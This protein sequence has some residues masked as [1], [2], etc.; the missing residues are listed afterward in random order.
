MRNLILAFLCVLV[1]VACDDSTPTS[2]T[3][4]T[5]LATDAQSDAAD[6]AEVDPHSCDGYGAYDEWLNV[7]CY[8][9]SC[10]DC[11]RGALTCSFKWYDDVGGCA[12]A[13]GEPD[14][15][16]YRYEYSVAELVWPSDLE[17]RPSS[18]VISCAGYEWMNRAFWCTPG[19]G[20]SEWRTCSTEEVVGM[21]TLYCEKTVNH[22]PID[23]KRLTIDEAGAPPDLPTLTV[24]FSSGD[25]TVCF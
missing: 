2:P 8:D 12:L 3:S 19:G 7:W 15:S 11:F 17:C 1:F 18:A 6:T 9:S 21:C 16:G 14:S 25:I 24:E 22:R 4:D 10:G 23:D 5:V 13:C 20:Q